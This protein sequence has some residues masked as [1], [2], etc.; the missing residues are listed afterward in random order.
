VQVVTTSLRHL[1]A[2]QMVAKLQNVR[3]AAEAMHLT[4]PAV[5]L[6]VANLEEQA[7][8]TLFERSR[9]GTYLTPAGEL[10]LLRVDRMFQQV[11][12]ALVQAGA[13]PTGTAT[14]AG[15]I[16]RSQIRALAS[17]ALDTQV[18]GAGVSR[19]STHR[20]A[21]E[22]ERSLGLDL[23]RPASG[24]IEVTSAGAELAQRLTVALAEA[25]AGIEDIAAAENSRLGLLRVGALP[26]SGCFLAGPVFNEIIR[27]FPDATVEIRTGD[28]ASL[29]RALRR[30][31]LDVVVGLLAEERA[32]E[33][34]AHEPLVEMPY[35]LVA[36]KGHPL[37]RRGRLAPADLAACTWVA[38]SL[39]SARREAFDRLV[40]HRGGQVANVQASSIS[41][42][43]LLISG[44]D[45][46]A[47]LT[48]FEL[49]HER[50]EDALV[51]LDVGPIEPTHWLG[52]TRRADWV[53]TPMQREFIELLRAQARRVAVRGRT[54]APV[55]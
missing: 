13:A 7:G 29:T 2:F 15:R 27:H 10:L 30:G 42:L 3:R 49:E 23:L 12:E 24:G 35:V 51:A 41:T 44:S 50:G 43:R 33:G 53:P 16:T 28:K 36:R 11:E 25:D 9:R 32:D 6:A 20:A 5:T 4:Q 1:R 14:L 45:R 46:L 26:L 19:A 8:A 54:S 37:A 17:L 22:L 21:R 55:T 18:V 39:G 40:S 52:L 47:L 38:P 31:D 48:S 34:L